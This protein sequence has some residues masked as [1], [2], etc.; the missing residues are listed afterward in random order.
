MV[1]WHIPTRMICRHT[2]AAFRGRDQT[3]LRDNVLWYINGIR[4]WMTSNR[5]KLNP[6]K[7]EFMLCATI[8]S[9]WST[10]LRSLFK[11]YQSFV[12]HQSDN[13][14]SS[15]ILCSI[16]QPRSR[17]GNSAILLETG[18][19]DHSRA[20]SIPS[21]LRVREKYVNIAQYRAL[22]IPSALRVTEKK[23][24]LILIR[25][26]QSYLS[27]FIVSLAMRVNLK[28]ERLVAYN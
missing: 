9:V 21:A 12:L 18:S 27:W 20:L 26:S 3:T 23:F 15:L 6:T 1:S 13:L 17:P 19:I 22:S 7:T 8:C 10:E 14:E 4:Q 28:A 11:M 2:E 24:H 5:L 25:G 16:C